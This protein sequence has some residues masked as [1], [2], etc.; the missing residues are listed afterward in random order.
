[1]QAYECFACRKVSSFTD[2]DDQSKCPSCGSTKVSL[3]SAEQLKE[4]R[5]AGAYFDIDPKTGKRAKTK[6]R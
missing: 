4:G 2:R 5:E 6:K 1:M 3:L